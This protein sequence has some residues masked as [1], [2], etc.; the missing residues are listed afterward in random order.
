MPIETQRFHSLS[1]EGM[2]ELDDPNELDSQP[3][4]RERRAQGMSSGSNP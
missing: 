1:V 2:A 4:A 3:T